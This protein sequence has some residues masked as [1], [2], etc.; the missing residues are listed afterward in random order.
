MPFNNLYSVRDLP[1]GGGSATLVKSAKIAVSGGTVGGKDTVPGLENGMT[2]LAGTPD[3]PREMSSSETL[4][5]NELKTRRDG[6]IANNNDQSKF[7]SEKTLAMRNSLFSSNSSDIREPLTLVNDTLSKLQL[8]LNQTAD[9][10]KLLEADNKPT[11]KLQEF[12]QKVNGL[13]NDEKSLYHNIVTGTTNPNLDGFAFYGRSSQVDGSISG[14]AILPVNHMKSWFPDLTDPQAD[15]GYQRI[16]GGMK[17]GNSVLPVMLPYTTGADKSITSK[18]GGDT[19]TAATKDTILAPVAG[20]KPMNATSNDATEFNIADTNKYPIASTSL[21]NGQFAHTVTGLDDNGNPLITT[22]YKG[23]DGKVYTVDDNAKGQL[24][25]D[26]GM[27]DA[28]KNHSDFLSTDEAT[29]LGSTTPMTDATTV[30]TDRNPIMN[31]SIA[32]PH[33]ETPEQPG[34]FQKMASTASEVG[35]AVVNEA[36]GVIGRALGFFNNRINTPNKPNEAPARTGNDV[37]NSGKDIFNSSAANIQTSTPQ[38]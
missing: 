25:K 29:K 23:Q 17:M 26:P 1:G 22:Y 30:N 37:I 5:Y 38:Q 7:V 20:Q 9:Q 27:Y 31:G 24:Q 28:M 2:M 35:S 18:W 19:W 6:I 33:G 8:I 14:A 3:N 4:F 13:F 34:F 10:R 11:D 21:K 16:E 36:P 15:S 12:G 32:V